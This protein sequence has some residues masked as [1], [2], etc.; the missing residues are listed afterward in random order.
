M[1]EATNLQA[2]STISAPGVP[3]VHADTALQLA[4]RETYGRLTTR[5]R[6]GFLAEH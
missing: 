1:E 5:G 3:R 4:S 6:S 2:A